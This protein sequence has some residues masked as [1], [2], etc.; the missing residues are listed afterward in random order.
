ML[1]TGYNI[2]H[3]KCIRNYLTV[4]FSKNYRKLLQYKPHSY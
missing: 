3:F 2:K 1:N 4:F